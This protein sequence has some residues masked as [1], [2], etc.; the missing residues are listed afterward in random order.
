MKIDLWNRQQKS[1]A[2]KDVMNGMRGFEEV[3]GQR[4]QPENEKENRPT[5][6]TF[7]FRAVGIHGSC[8]CELNAY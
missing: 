2:A 6:T 7:F 5:R 3:I 8:Q 4:K 1:N